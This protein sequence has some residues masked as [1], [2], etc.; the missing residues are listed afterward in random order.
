MHYLFFPNF[1]Y[2]TIPNGYVEYPAERSLIPDGNFIRNAGSSISF[3]IIVFVLVLI[4]SCV[5]LLLYKYKRLEEMPQI[6]KITRIGIFFAHI[7]FLNIVFSATNFL[8][9][10]SMSTNSVSFWHATKIAAIIM[11][12][13]VVL[14]CAI[15]TYHFYKTYNSD[16][17]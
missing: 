13:F 10:P 16:V 12:I 3:L 17:L 8:F 4:A 7:T 14:M 5:S 6:R 9:Q 11:L 15:F 1:F 2:S